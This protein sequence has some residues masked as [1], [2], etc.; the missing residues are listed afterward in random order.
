MLKK[1]ILIICVNYNSY[2]ELSEYLKTIDRSSSHTK[3]VASI[4]VYV[5]DNTVENFKKIDISPYQCINITVKPFHENL[6]YLGGVNKVIES[7]K[8]SD[9]KIY[10]YVIISNVDLFMS[11]HF[12]EI[13]LN[14]NYDSQIGWITPRIISLQDK[15]DKNPRMINRPSLLKMKFILFLYKYSYLFYFYKKILHHFAR[16]K[17][18]TN[19]N[20][21]IYAGH[22]SFMI[23][24]KSFFKVVDNI[25]FDSFLYA[26]EIFFAELI[27]KTNLKVFYDRSIFIN[28]IEH[29]STK[30]IKRIAWYKMNQDSIR[31]LIE[32][33][34]K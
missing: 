16:K 30:K 18:T 28:D 21:I 22:G 20:E 31:M 14:N 7:N 25:R 26:E 29:I 23:F 6:G 9:L 4:D 27:R 5:A 11:E 33:F 1:K 32:R 19:T 10:D 17:K 24:T 15:N 12:L 2:N 13:L 8:I 3:E 34:W